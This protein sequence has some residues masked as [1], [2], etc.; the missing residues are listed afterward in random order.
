MQMDRS[1]VATTL[2]TFMNAPYAMFRNT[3]IGAKE[4]LRNPVK[5]LK[6]IERM[7]FKKAMGIAKKRIDAQVANEVAQGI[8]TK[9][10]AEQRKK[11]LIAG[12]EEYVMPHVESV[13]KKKRRQA[14]VKAAAMVFL[15]GYAG[16][17][18]FN[19]MGKLWEFMFGDDDEEK[20]KLLYDITVKSA[21]EAPVSMMPLGG[22]VTSAINGYSASVLPA[23]DELFKEIS[24]IAKGL[25]EEDISPEVVYAATTMCMRWGLGLSVDTIVNI[26]LGL[27]NM[28]EEGVSP[29]AILKVINAPEKQIRSIVGQRREGETAK[30]YTERVMRFYSIADT[31][32]YEDYYYTHG[33][34]AGKRKNEETPRGMF[35]KEMNRIKYE[36][37]HRRDV[38]LT[39]A[40][41]KELADIEETRKA[42]RKSI[43]EGYGKLSEAKKEHLR[44]LK[45]KISDRELH[46]MR[47]MDDTTYYKVLTS[48]TALQKEYIEK[49]EQFK[50]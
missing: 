43:S 7:E 6:E 14:K 49:Y 2:S 12:A 34:K 3:M 4:I 37:A 44:D 35:N 10:E 1:I 47:L 9:E 20:K 28:I 39:F 32:I 29:E 50:Q 16:Q 21:W 15:N 17:V 36:D 11:D 25:R 5:Q 40:N 23:T 30:E 26:A 31:P 18:A 48:E 41:G 45:K 33:E 46:L 22:Y 8:Y 19:L 24:T 13:A 38:V 42:Y 27:E